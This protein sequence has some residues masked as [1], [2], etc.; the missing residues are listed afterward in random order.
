MEAA[1]NRIGT[2]IDQVM[3]RCFRYDPQQGRYTLVVM[4]VLK[5]GAFATLLG[6]SLLIGSLVVVDRRRRSGKSRG[7]TP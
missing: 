2:P 1:E 4:E 7:R 6:L 5:L 3:M